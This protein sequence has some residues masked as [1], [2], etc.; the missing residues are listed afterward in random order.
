MPYYVPR[1]KY[2]KAY[3]PKFRNDLWEHWG[4]LGKLIGYPQIVF[5]I[6]LSVIEIVRILYGPTYRGIS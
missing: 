6:A 2:R 4:P 3:P 5:G 1:I